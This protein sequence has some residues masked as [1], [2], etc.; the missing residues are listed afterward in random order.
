MW[1]W[2]HFHLRRNTTSLIHMLMNSRS[3]VD[4]AE[5]EVDSAAP[6]ARV[7][8]DEELLGMVQTESGQAELVRIVCSERTRQSHV[9]SALLFRFESSIIRPCDVFGAIRG[10]LLAGAPLLMDLAAVLVVRHFDSIKM[11]SKPPSLRTLLMFYA[12]DRLA[13]FYMKISEHL[14][15]VNPAAIM[16][17]RFIFEESAERILANRDMKESLCVF[18]N[19]VESNHLDVLESLIDDAL[20]IAILQV[21][22][23]S[24]ANAPYAL[25]F[26]SGYVVFILM[27]RELR[28][29]IIAFVQRMVVSRRSHMMVHFSDI[30]AK[31]YS[32]TLA[33][34]PA[35]STG[36]NLLVPHFSRCM[37][38]EE[39]LT[40]AVFKGIKLLV[41]W[42]KLTSD[43]CHELSSAYI[44]GRI[45]F[46]AN[47]P[48]SRLAPTVAVKPDC[49]MT[50]PRSASG[51]TD[52]MIEETESMEEFILCDASFSAFALLNLVDPIFASGN[53]HA[54]S[55]L[56]HMISGFINR[57]AT[58]KDVGLYFAFPG[59]P[60][61]ST[62]IQRYAQQ[63][64]V[65]VT[66][67]TK[68]LQQ[69]MQLLPPN[70]CVRFLKNAIG[71]GSKIE[72]TSATVAT[73]ETT[74]GSEIYASLKISAR[75]ISKRIICSS[76]APESMIIDAIGILDSIKFPMNTIELHPSASIRVIKVFSR[77]ARMT[78]PEMIV[79]A[80]SVPHLCAAFIGAM[81]DDR[82]TD[83]IDE[84]I[85]HASSYIT[86]MRDCASRGEEMV[87][88][89]IM[90][91]LRTCSKTKPVN[92]ESYK[93]E[94]FYFA[95]AVADM[96]CAFPQCAD[97]RINV[98]LLMAHHDLV[99]CGII[100]PGSFC[101][102]APDRLLRLESSSRERLQSIHAPSLNHKHRN[103]IVH[104]INHIL[105]HKRFI[106]EPHIIQSLMETTQCSMAACS[107]DGPLPEPIMVSILKE[108]FSDRS[109]FSNR[110]F[111]RAALNFAHM[112]RNKLGIMYDTDFFDTILAEKRPDNAEEIRASVERW[113]S[114][115][116]ELRHGDHDRILQLICLI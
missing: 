31:V 46:A 71:M 57:L 19:M 65:C 110:T 83:A 67:V 106:I 50:V 38:A 7:Y 43:I 35:N 114:G 105:V 21:A 90:H 95:L 10:P 39:N 108:M 62:P 2:I 33:Y 81:K 115:T 37:V 59:M 17:F 6:T 79:R 70:V 30:I 58:P 66:L 102:V 63:T 76:D 69:D 54:I 89:W 107:E 11:V 73:L 94:R 12:G 101:I 49:E 60:F 48:M 74:L 98:M 88:R 113:K 29:H 68:V 86:S 47:M 53:P 93:T 61:G 116:H 26:I 56:V 72:S 44:T 16:H 25:Q 78:F 40:D 1:C 27:K 20:M 45:Q 112:F 85:R 15:R 100:S 14:T 8:T 42:E 109:I 18:L 28:E 103:G 5:M 96:I 24:N 36:M 64:F 32:S 99:T 91:V 23:S 84:I 13:P 51:V 75:E 104:F 22:E 4:L 55:M 111:V 82:R 87:A 52:D 77:Y 97:D 34:D 3:Q 41:E 92:V 9:A 80:K